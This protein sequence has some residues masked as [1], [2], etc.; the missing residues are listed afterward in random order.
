MRLEYTRGGSTE[1]E[2]ATT[3]A[4]L[5]EPLNALAWVANVLGGQGRPL[6]AGMWVMTGSSLRTRFA[7]AGDRAVYT[8]EG[9]GSVEVTV[10]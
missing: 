9:L 8:V 5:G 6:E 7:E 4:A 10:T 2:T 1:V 3:G